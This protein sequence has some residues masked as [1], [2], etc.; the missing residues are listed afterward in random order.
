MYMM[1]S[2]GVQFWQV[3]LLAVIKDSGSLNFPV[4]QP[5]HVQVSLGPLLIAIWEFGLGEL[6][7]IV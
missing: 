6:I 5:S 3:C 4:K 2:A 7:Q 1:S